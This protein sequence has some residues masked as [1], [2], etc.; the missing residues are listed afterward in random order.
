MKKY[1][2]L[3]AGLMGRVV[4]KDIVE[5]APDAQ[6]TLIDIN[7]ALLKELY[8]F[9]GQTKLK[10]CMLN[11]SDTTATASIL[12]KHDVV[13]SALPHRLSLPAIKAAIKACV[14]IVDLVGEAP[15]KRLALHHEAENV[16]ITIIP[17]CGVAP[18][19]SNICVGRGVELLDETHEA[20]IYVGGLPKK[21]EPPLYYQTVYSLESVFDAY[22]RKA[23]ILRK[24][25]IVEVEPMSGVEKINF[26]EP[27]GQLEAFYTDGL[28]SLIVTMK[29]KISHHLAEKT[30][31]YP[32]HRD[33]IKLLESCGMLEE[34]PVLINSHEITPLDFLIKQLSNVLKL[35]PD[36]DLL[37][38]RIVIKG[39]KDGTSR[40]HTFELFDQ[41]DP[42]N[43]IT[44]MARTT[45]F[46]AVWAARMITDKRINKK[47]VQFPEQIFS[48]E[49]FSEFI[50]AM[51]KNNIQISHS[52]NI[53]DF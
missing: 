3:G 49:L 34:K 8:N 51:R 26:P 50:S 44:A 30:L 24:G 9:I 37:I 40:T 33:R 43:Q 27:M 20:I 10:V 5:K 12:R 17:G 36:G 7:E 19:I 52:I 35:S 48:T 47:G 2:V 21:K 38:M 14:S 1:A 29:G 28:A 6:V 15:E 31:R 22:L 46:P 23:R 39:I 45:A 41:F 16:G 4:V 32:G 53:H 42:A 11:V 18:G 25:E 13:I